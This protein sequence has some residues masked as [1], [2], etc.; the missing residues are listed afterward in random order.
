[1]SDS[2]NAKVVNI[3]FKAPSGQTLGTNG[4]SSLRGMNKTTLGYN[5]DG[6]E[7]EINVIFSTYNTPATASI[8]L[9]ARIGFS[10][11]QQ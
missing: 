11:V 2:D 3:R 6:E 1:M 4:T 7:R 9:N 5:F 8:P 10:G